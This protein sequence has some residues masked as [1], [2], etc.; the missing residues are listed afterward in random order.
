MGSRDPRDCAKIGGAFRFGVDRAKRLCYNATPMKA[1]RARKLTW[2]VLLVFTVIVLLL[3]FSQAEPGSPYYLAGVAF[4]AAGQILRLWATGHLVKN[5][6]LTTTGP[7]QHVKN[8]LYLGTFLIMTGFCSLATGGTR[9]GH[10]ALDRMSW[11]LYA[12]AVTVFVLYYAPY[13]KRREGDHLRELYGEDWDLFD[14]NVPDY[15][16]RLT[17]FRHP[18][19]Q[20]VSWSW[21]TVCDNS[22]QWTLLA[23]VLGVA[24]ITKSGWIV[25]FVL[26]HVG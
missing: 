19:A 2:R 1:T 16:P 11:L 21:Q 25:D 7:F 14:R 3:Y 8:P 10:W 6:R 26:N 5:K 12:F 20:A 24:A 22:E 18:R 15:F 17:P 4:I 9:Y 13:K 23:V